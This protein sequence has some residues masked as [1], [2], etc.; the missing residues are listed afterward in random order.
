M[1][2]LQLAQLAFIDSFLPT[3]CPFRRLST[4][5]PS[6]ATRRATRTN[7]G[8]AVR[9]PFVR[10]IHSPSSCREPL[11]CLRRLVLSIEL[12]A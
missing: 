4:I 7:I 6:R 1:L 3:G 12:Q 9:E 11:S 10:R 8:L 2:L 5:S